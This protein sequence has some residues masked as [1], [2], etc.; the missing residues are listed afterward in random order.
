LA[1]TSFYERWYWDG[2]KVVPLDLVITP[3]LARFWFYG[4]GSSTWTGHRKNNVV[5]T[6]CTDSFTTDE[7]EFLRDQW[8]KVCPSV[9]FSITSNHRLR[10]YSQASIS[11]FL[12]FMGQPE[13]S[14]F[15]YK[16]KRPLA[17][18]SGGLEARLVAMDQI[19][20]MRATG[21]SYNRIAATLIENGVVN[22]RGRINW[23]PGMV[24]R[25][26]HPKPNKLYKLW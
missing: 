10:L 1:L 13:L 21:L 3:T 23:D 11:A 16:W 8:L 4:D 9:R 18:A 26:F 6:L 20:S 24:W 14:C 7:C 2:H 5:V 12:D 17:L 22:S 19:K 25:L 15:A